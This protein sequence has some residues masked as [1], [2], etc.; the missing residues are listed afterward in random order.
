MGRNTKRSNS[1]FTRS[2]SSQEFSQ[3][4]NRIIVGNLGNKKKEPVVIN[5]LFS[6]DDK[7]KPN[8]IGNRIIRIAQEVIDD[9]KVNSASDLFSYSS[10]ISSSDEAK[11][12]HKSISESI[13]DYI[14]QQY[15]NLENLSDIGAISNFWNCLSK[16]INILTTCLSP[17]SLRNN[18]IPLIS[19]V[20]KAQI[21]EYYSKNN[22]VYEQLTSIVID[23]FQNNEIDED[24]RNSF[25][26]AQFCCLF[27]T[28]F[29]PNLYRSITEQLEPVFNTLFEQELSDYLREAI[30]IQKE[31]LDHVSKLVPSASLRTLQNLLNRIIFSSK[32]DQIIKNGLPTL[33][34]NQDARSLAL[35]VSF[36]KETD[37]I[38]LFVKKLS[39]IFES[40][41]ADCFKHEDPIMRVLN[42][43]QTM[44]LFNESAKFSNDDIRIIRVAFEKG[45]NSSPDVA[46]RL[47]A[48]EINKQFISMR[49]IDQ[50]MLFHLLSIFKMLFCKDV[51]ARYHA[52][53]LA[54]RVLLLQGHTISVDQEFL[55][56]LVVLCGPDYTK[57]FK[58]I[59][60]DLAQSQAI[61]KKFRDD[62]NP[63]KWFKC[64]MF[65]R[66]TWPSIEPVP[67]VLPKEIHLMM[68]HYIST[69]ISLCGK[70]KIQYSPVLTRVKLTVKGVQGIREIKCS[71]LVAVY[72]L[73]FNI[74]KSISLQQIASSIKVDLNEIESIT[75]ILQ[76]NK[77]GNLVMLLHHHKVRI[78][79][80][81]NIDGGCLNIPFILPQLSQQDDDKTKNAILQTRDSQIDAAIVLLLKKE[82][83][84]EKED[85]RMRI[86]DSL[87]FI[88]DD[89]LF[90]NR[91]HS[92][93]VKTLIKVDASGKVNYIP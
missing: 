33:V 71:G 29:V 67:H 34:K 61:M 51:F 68:S 8:Q 43:H 21:N 6:K 88:M 83:S 60:D 87:K 38:T 50:N 69:A 42:L 73:L 11:M 15:S 40:S 85:I 41:S 1:R 59:F 53:L 5:G 57:P 48:V 92:L 76:S 52:H 30:K 23:C 19:E 65:S 91:L 80:E 3:S 4:I 24:L 46:A 79:P 18:Q 75:D 36:A 90:E 77:G 81:A 25:K 9:S 7:L 37:T 26:F 49:V 64:L 14:S 74:E 2:D 86:K 56:E 28:Y 44:V 82:K 35:C 22:Q 39:F 31:Q 66:E 20:F 55:K 10:L 84:L 78:N 89:E 62:H 17:L 45:F 72:L 27:D 16:K 12:V 58:L 32:F 54:K 70:R 47:L 93:H 13:K 63:P